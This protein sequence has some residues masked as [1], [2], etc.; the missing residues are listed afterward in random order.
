M[1]DLTSDIQSEAG[2]ITGIA[3][4]KHTD[5]GNAERLAD[6]ADGKLLWVYGIGWLFWD[7]KRWK[8][9]ESNRHLRVAA[10]TARAIHEEAAF[11]SS[12]AAEATDE[13]ERDKW[14]A[15]AKA[16]NNW[17]RQ[18]ES[19]NRI[20]S[21]LRLATAQPRLVLEEGAKGLDADPYALNV[22]NGVLDLRNLQLRRHDPAERHTRIAN[23]SYDPDAAAP[24][25][26]DCIERALP[27][28]ELRRWVQKAAGY[29]LPGTH[30]EY[31]FIPH[32]AGANGKSTIETAWR[33]ALGDYA[34]EAPS[35]LLVARR[36]WGAQG[37][38]ALAGLRGCRLVT[39]TETEQGKALAEVLT[40]KLT[41]ESEITAKFMRQDY[42][43][44]DNQMSVWLATNYK[45]VVQ[46]GDYAIWRRIRLIPFGITIPPEERLEQAEVARRLKTERD[47]I[48]AWL[49]EGWRMFRDEGLTPEPDAVTAATES[50]REEMDPLAEWLNEEFEDDPE[51]TVA[52]KAIKAAYARWTKDVGRNALGDRRF[53]ELMEARGYTRPDSAVRLPITLED[54]STVQQRVKVWKGL[55]PKPPGA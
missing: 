7:G 45:P 10:D 16:A 52:I 37:E 3:T 35:D 55:R 21:M 31:L 49:V 8:R 32:G 14:A 23:A 18:S 33:D 24:F 25:F 28:P 4:C 40:K 20:S 13:A 26:H 43:T 53:N 29:S 2:A 5:L 41:G 54:G 12:Q 19:G 44:F 51:G 46:G 39:A 47:G 30:S 48:L 34:A 50:Y 27:D 15:L 38:S 22:Q 11:F 6:R 1:Q 42:F 36:E 9:D 17:A